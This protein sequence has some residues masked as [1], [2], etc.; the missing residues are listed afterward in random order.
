MNA[1]I[2]K[3]DHLPVA[4]EL[5]RGSGAA[6]LT[7]RGK[8]SRLKYFW[9][10]FGHYFQSFGFVL[11]GATILSVSP[12]SALAVV[13]RRALVSALSSSG[14]CCGPCRARVSKPEPG[15]VQKAQLLLV[16][17]RAQVDY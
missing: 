6:R 10:H 2:N 13:L 17:L 15:F 16:D 1:Y 5:E 11:L 4:A 8:S 14:P 9:T 12:A 3:P 7:F